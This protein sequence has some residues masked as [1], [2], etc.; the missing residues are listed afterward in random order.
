MT[1]NMWN[2]KIEY[3]KVVSFPYVSIQVMI[4]LIWHIIPQTGL[5]CRGPGCSL[6]AG[7]AWTG[8]R[9]ILRARFVCVFTVFERSRFTPLQRN[10]GCSHELRARSQKINFLLPP[11]SLAPAGHEIAFWSP[12][13]SQSIQKWSP[14]DLHTCT[15]TC[16]HT[17]IHTHMHTYIDTY[18]H[19]CIHTYYHTLHACIHT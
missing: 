12:S 10:G 15:H 11:A 2:M 8:R 16:I 7:R 18:I 19:T 3:I 6:E 14:N 9:T 17:R 5:S 13:D 1:A 4:C